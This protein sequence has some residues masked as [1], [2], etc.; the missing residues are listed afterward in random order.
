MWAVNAPPLKQ[1]PRGSLNSS[2]PRYCDCLEELVVDDGIKTL[3]IYLR[4]TCRVRSTAHFD[5]I[6]F[7]PLYY[8][9]FQQFHPYKI[10]YYLCLSEPIEV[11]VGLLFENVLT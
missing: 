9:V 3:A 5:S 10:I 6:Y 4:A 11:K 1:C 7:R 2:S 8:Y